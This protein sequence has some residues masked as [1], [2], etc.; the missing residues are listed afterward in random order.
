MT[1]EYRNGK[2][3]TVHCTG[4]DKGKSIACFPTKEAAFRQ[5]RA[6]EANKIEI[7]LGEL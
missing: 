4:K 1:V 7:N 3:C 2:W 5:H 6:I